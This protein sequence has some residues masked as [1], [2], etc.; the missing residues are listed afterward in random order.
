MNTKLR[1]LR[2]ILFRA[3]YN[4]PVMVGIKQGIFARHGLEVDIVHTRG[5]QMVTESLLRGDC[6]LGVLAADDVVY[7]VETHGRD[8]FI[9]MGLHSGILQLIARPGIGDI[10]HL[11]GGKL[12]VDDPASGFALVAHRILARMGLPKSAY[13][14]LAMGGHE[15]RARALGEGKIDIALSTPPFSLEL[16]SR[17][18]ELLARADEHIPRYQGSCGVATRRWAADNADAL[19]AYKR[20]Y[21]ES[22]TWTIDPINRDSGIAELATE[23]TLAPALAHQTFDAIT[24]PRTGL[25]ADARID[26]GGLRAVLDLRIE[27]GLL[28]DSA[29]EPT[30]YV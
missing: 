8:L 18:F 28:S 17:G 29:A 12:G 1:R 3:A 27:A 22:L 11:A 5:S 2:V 23:F 21:Q 15:P 7:E 14:T 26:M 19:T 25:Y 13:Q 20:A 6:D 9:F 30:K 10:R 24:D 4:L 16:L